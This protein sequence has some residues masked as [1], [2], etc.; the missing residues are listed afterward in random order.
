[1]VVAGMLLSDGTRLEGRGVMPDIVQEDDWLIQPAAEDVW[2]LTAVR[3]LRRS[4]QES[5]A[6]E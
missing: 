1:M 3:E 2:V 6:P 5:A 4:S